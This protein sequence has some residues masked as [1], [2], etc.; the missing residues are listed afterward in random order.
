MPAHQIFNK[1]SATK[2]LEDEKAHGETDIIERH[3]ILFMPGPVGCV[4]KEDGPVMQPDDNMAHRA[5]PTPA[6]ALLKKSAPALDYGGIGSVL[7][8]VQE[9]HHKDPSVPSTDCSKS[10]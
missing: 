1:F 10:Y 5:S 6:A 8:T 4:T 7:R 9:H 2:L 3:S